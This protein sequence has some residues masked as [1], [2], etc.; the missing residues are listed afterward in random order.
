M[1]YK[2]IKGKMTTIVQFD[3]S[4]LQTVVKNCLRDAIEEIRTIPTQEEI[5]DRCSLP[6]AC[7]LTGV[8]PS[9]MYKLSM[10]GEVPVDKFGR[11]LVFSRRKLIDWLEENTFP[12]QSP[13]EVM[14]DALKG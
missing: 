10:T 2:P 8:S 14:A 12:K 6:E 5:S 13:A 11:K 7:E 4:E 1:H 3:Y 9:K